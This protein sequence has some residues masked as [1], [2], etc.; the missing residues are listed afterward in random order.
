M[1]QVSGE[2]QSTGLVRFR[3][4]TSDHTSMTAS[5]IHTPVRDDEAVRE[6]DTCCI[7]AILHKIYP[8]LTPYLPAF[9]FKSSHVHGKNACSQ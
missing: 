6:E 4:S 2:T 9:V 7:K 1:I 3:V 5:P 8:P